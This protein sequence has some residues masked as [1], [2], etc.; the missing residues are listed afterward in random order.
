LS[1]SI[2]EGEREGFES[3]V[4]RSDVYDLESEWVV[5]AGMVGCSLRHGGE[6]LLGQRGGLAG[7]VERGSSFGIPLLAPWANR[8]SGLTYSAAGRDVDLDAGRTPLKLDGNGLPMHGLLTASPLWEV[9]EQGAGEGGAFVV[10]ALDFG[11]HGELLAGFPF[12]HR[13]VVSARITEGVL[14]VDT[15][16]EA[17][18]DMAVPVSFGWHPYLTLPGVGRSA[19]EV[20][21]PVRR[22]AMLDERGLP[23]GDIEEVDRIAGALGDDAYDDLFPDLHSLTTFALAGGG[24]R[25]E[26]RFAWG[27]PVAQVYAP[28]GEPFICFEP[29]TAPTDALRSGHGLRYVAPGATFSARFAIAVAGA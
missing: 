14:V 19:W 11:A 29:M 20:D 15:D 18:G 27:Y 21:M 9:E 4:L 10:A 24:R 16:L 8:L 17:T 2:T 7:Y 26:V 3:V 28:P 6:E 1:Y 13:L 23:T 12:P 22:R 5:G 25:L